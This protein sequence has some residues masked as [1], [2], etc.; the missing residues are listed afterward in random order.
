MK[1]EACRSGEL[2]SPVGDCWLG[3]FQGRVSKY[4]MRLC[5]KEECSVMFEYIDEFVFDSVTLVAEGEIAI[6]N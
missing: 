4:V 6:E 1:N 3:K 2:C 5:N